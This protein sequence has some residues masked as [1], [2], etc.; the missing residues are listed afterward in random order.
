MQEPRPEEF[1]LT[2][3][4]LDVVDERLWRFRV[5]C[6]VLVGFGA[7]LIALYIFYRYFS[8]RAASELV[9][10]MLMMG[11]PISIFAGVASGMAVFIALLS[12]PIALWDEHARVRRYRAALAAYEKR[13]QSV[14]VSR[15]AGLSAKRLQTQVCDLYRRLGYEVEAAPAGEAESVD[16]VLRK[17]KLQVLVNCRLRKA[18]IEWRQVWAL[19]EAQKRQGA[20]HG[21]FVSIPGFTGKARRYAAGKPLGLISVPEL[22]RI[23]RHLEAEE[24]GDRESAPQQVEG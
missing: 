17:D 13:R 1:G 9:T 3:K 20:D 5:A 23:E 12:L 2:E 11:L 18:P 10:N 24:S 21:L 15:W 22:A 6:A 8:A 4:Q 14:Y 16:F 7:F 19:H